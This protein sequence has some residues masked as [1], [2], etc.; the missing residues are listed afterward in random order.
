MWKQLVQCHTASTGQSQDSNPSLGNPK[1]AAFYS[2][3]LH[4][5]MSQKREYS[6]PIPNLLTLGPLLFPQRKD[7]KNLQKVEVSVSSCSSHLSLYTDTWLHCHE[8]RE[9]GDGSEKLRKEA[10][11]IAPDIGCQIS[12]SAM[13]PGLL[14]LLF[15]KHSSR[16]GKAALGILLLFKD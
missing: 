9:S 6:L 5:V 16:Q 10:R 13:N 15:R 3:S 7:L 8:Q 1:A 12:L 4:K 2:F 11:V 14:P